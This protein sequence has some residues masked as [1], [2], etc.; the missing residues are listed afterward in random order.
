MIEHRK[1]HWLVMAA[2][3]LTLAII[4]TGTGAIS[5]PASEI[6]A[7]IQGSGD[8][9]TVSI[10]RHLRL[11]RVLLA[12]LV[13]AGLGMSGGAL[14]G[15]LRNG[16]AEPYLL[17][18]SGGAAVGAVTALALNATGNGIVAI[19]AFIG[20]ATAVLLALLVARAAGAIGRGDPRTLLMAGVVIGAFANAVIMIALANA[21][22]N[23]IRGALWWMM[24]SVADGSWSAIAWLSVYVCLGGGALLYWAREVDILALGDEAAA[25]LGIDVEDATRRM[26]LLAALLAASTVAAAGLIGFVGLIVPHI[27]RAA[28]IRHHRPLLVAAALIG[29]TLV[30]AAD[31]VARTVRPPG[32]LPLGAVT[33][34]LGVPFFL[35]QLRRVR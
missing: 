22:P 29:A 19:A 25:G 10:V 27:A 2:A 9:A 1:W 33:A 17:G 4:A 6:I 21:P 11:P 12:A 31:L 32:E 28:G 26:Y 16:L 30:I 24:G 5:I 18:V 7:G 20:A 13:G 35:A 14:Q 15:T 8:P 3:L 23:T 34:V